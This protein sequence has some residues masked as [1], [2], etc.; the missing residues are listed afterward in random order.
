MVRGAHSQFYMGELEQLLPEL[1][2]KNFVPI[3]S[4]PP[5]I[6]AA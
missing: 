5:E 6:H 4:M 3:K 2:G 1:T